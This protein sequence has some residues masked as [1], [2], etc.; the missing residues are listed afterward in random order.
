MKLLTYDTGSGPRC[1]VLR[2]DQ[3]VD[4]TALLGADQTLRDL[5]ALLELGD[6]PLDHVQD[7]LASNIAAP[8]CR[9]TASGCA[10]RCSSRRPYAT[11]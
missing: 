8:L 6:S 4:V 3:V 2:D 9:W 1:G 11:S 10:R 5:R 7:A